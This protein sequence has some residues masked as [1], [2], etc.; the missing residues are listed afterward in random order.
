MD[1][2]ASFGALRAIDALCR[3]LPTIDETGPLKQNRYVGVFYFL[4]HGFGE[5]PVDGPN[6]VTRIL[7]ES[8]EAIK[9]F[10]HPAWGNGGPLYWGE[11]LYG[12]YFTQDKW[13]L[14]RHVKMLTHALVDFIVF[15]TTNRT[16]FFTQVL[17]IL[18][19]LDEYRLEGF[20][21]PKIVYYTNTQS[22]ETVSE[23]Y[24]D[25]YKKGLYPELWF[26]WEGKPLISAL[27]DEC[28]QEERDFFPFRLSQWPA[29]K[30][31]TMGCP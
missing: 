14:R 11:P 23:I 3:R 31:K 6:D 5:R 10:D 7:K 26:H 12:Y 27:P 18:E 13:V 28:G 30:K 20:D 15:D 24:R 16:T 2:N 17:P 25:V 9:N 1:K 29:E 21:V 8:P 22:G 4:T 19:V